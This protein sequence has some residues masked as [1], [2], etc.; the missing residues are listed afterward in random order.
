[1]IHSTYPNPH[2]VSAP[3]LEETNIMDNNMG[4]ELVV[5]QGPYYPAAS[6]YY[7]YYCTGLESAGLWEDHYRFFGLDGL[8]PQYTGVQTENLPYVYYTPSYGYADSPYNPYNPYIPG[9]VV[10]IDS[11]FVGPQQYYAGP[12]CD[13]PVSSSGYFPLL[14]QPTADVLPNTSVDTIML[15]GV[16]SAGAGV[17]HIAPSNSSVM[18]ARPLSSGPDQHAHTTSNL[19]I[20]SSKISE[21]VQ[22]K[23]ASSKQPAS[24]ADITPS[25]ISISTS[26]YVNQNRSVSASNKPAENFAFGRAPMHNPLKASLPV[27][28]GFDFG[29]DAHGWAAMHKLRNVGS[30]AFGEQN[31]GPRTSRLKNKWS[32][33][34]AVKEYNA[35]MGGSHAQGNIII[36]A[37]QYNKEDFPV[38]YPNA[39]FFVIK[40]YSEDDIHKS[41]KYSVWSSTPV[42]N[43]KLDSAFEDAHR[44]SCGKPGTCPVFLFFSVN[45]SGQFCGVAE[46]ISPVDYNKDMDFWQQDKWSGSF[47]VKWHIIKDVPNSSFRHVILENN[48]NKPVTNSRDTQEVLYSPG[49]EML[50]IFKNYSSRTS[51]LDDFIYYESRQKIR[52]EEKLRLLK[53]YDSSFFLPSFVSVS[54]PS[55]TICQPLNANKNVPK[56]KEN[57]LEKKSVTVSD[58]SVSEQDV[59][60]SSLNSKNMVNEVVEENKEITSVTKK[61]SSL[62]TDSSKGSVT[63]SGSVTV[64]PTIDVVTV[65]SIPVR[66]NGF[67]DSNDGI[68][69]IGTISIDPKSARHEK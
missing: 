43:K 64:R 51:L 52:Q 35:K 57:C 32:S 5:D 8:D 54:K 67:S 16:S 12:A 4:T 26:S 50:K 29:S 14:V 7:G 31:R 46:M 15:S 62:S 61:M 24:Y 13:I 56:Q 37:D 68:L 27:N 3:P 49:M 11:P 28:N 69:T 59:Q 17:K 1:M 58:Q 41:I 47:P 40:S 2:L 22:V 34:I 23:S 38:N 55:V 44:I 19:A 45:A 39:K 66:V 48:E 25:G 9:A 53:S 18:V 36:Y 65:G 6:N 42:G 33:S 60:D 20:P 63:I 21:V 10:A 30:D